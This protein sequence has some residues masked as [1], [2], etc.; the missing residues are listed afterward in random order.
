MNRSTPPPPKRRL[1]HRARC[2]PAPHRPILRPAFTVVE[3]A[4]T[5]V[6]LLVCIIGFAQLFST[7]V[8]QRHSGASV[9]QATDLAQN[10]LEE[11]SGLDPQ[12]L[13]DASFDQ[14]PF[15][16]LARRTLSDGQI[17]FQVRQV[18]P[19]ATDDVKVE[20]SKMPQG[21]PL[22]VLTVTVSWDFGKGRPHRNVSLSYMIPTPVR[23]STQ[24]PTEGGP[25]Q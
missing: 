16:L 10:V 25:E 4:A 11:L 12:T 6:L 9:R 1:R 23:T 15:R 22:D 2:R 18:E 7:T 13:R 5:S 8:D 3:L 19:V 20:P 21:P 24:T 14:E 17:A